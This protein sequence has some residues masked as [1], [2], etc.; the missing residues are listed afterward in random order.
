MGAPSARMCGATGSGP[1]V[2]GLPVFA[3]DPASAVPWSTGR[4]GRARGGAGQRAGSTDQGLPGPD[5]SWRRAH[6]RRIDDPDPVPGRGPP[7]GRRAAGALPLLGRGH[8]LR[9][10]ARG[11]PGRLRTARVSRGG[12]PRDA[13]QARRRAAPSEGLPVRGALRGRHARAPRDRRRLRDAGARLRG[14]A[15]LHAPPGQAPHLTARRR[16][17]AG[18]PRGRRGHDRLQRRGLDRRVLGERDEAHRHARPRGDR[19]PR[20]GPRRVGR[21][22]PGLAAL[23][24]GAGARRRVRHRLRGEAP[25]ERG[26]GRSRRSSPTR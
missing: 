25:R 14:S 16:R 2:P 11:R 24:G 6:D 3:P 1:I 9:H 4:T 17:P 18:R 20:V 21:A 15:A 23:A 19:V 10:P 8:R 12:V 7:H 26:P 5:R 13:G 22:P